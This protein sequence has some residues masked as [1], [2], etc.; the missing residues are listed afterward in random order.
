MKWNE[1]MV[2]FNS[3]ASASD[4]LFIQVTWKILTNISGQK[5]KTLCSGAFTMTQTRQR[6]RHSLDGCYISWE[7]MNAEMCWVSDWRPHLTFTPN[8]FNKK[9]KN[10]SAAQTVHELE[11]VHKIITIIFLCFLGRVIQASHVW[12]FPMYFSHGAFVSYKD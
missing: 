4:F 10:P 3:G 7:W 8:S 11:N 12:I 5:M 6:T 2:P 9:L 1:V